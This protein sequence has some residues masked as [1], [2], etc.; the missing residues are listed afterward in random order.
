MTVRHGVALVALAMFSVPALAQGRIEPGDFI[1]QGGAGK[2]SI[3]RSEKGA[4]EFDIEVF[5]PSQH[6]CGLAGEIRNGRASLETLDPR[7]RCVV[8]FKPK[9]RAST[10]SRR[11]DTGRP[12][13]YDA[14][15]YVAIIKAARTNLKPCGASK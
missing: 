11:R 1:T 8:T 14:T 4:L 6:V 15:P 3:K 12:P 9:G 10:S 7:K 2:L 5:A 13:P